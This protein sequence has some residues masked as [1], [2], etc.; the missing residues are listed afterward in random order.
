MMGTNSLRGTV[1]TNSYTSSEFRRMDCDQDEMPVGRDSYYSCNGRSYKK[2]R[3]GGRVM[4][5]PVSGIPIN[6]KGVKRL[7]KQ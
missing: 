5:V 6:L 1:C 2:E 3:V 4:Y 7:I